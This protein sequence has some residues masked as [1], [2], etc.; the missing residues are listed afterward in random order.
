MRLIP[1]WEFITNQLTNNPECPTEV[2]EA[3]ARLRDKL[4]E[5][6]LD[7]PTDKCIE[8]IIDVSNGNESLFSLVTDS[9]ACTACVVHNGECDF[10]PVNTDGNALCCDEYDIVADWLIHKK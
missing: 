4:K 7:A 2:I 3:S 10:C 6:E 1:K 8:A 5:L 9:D